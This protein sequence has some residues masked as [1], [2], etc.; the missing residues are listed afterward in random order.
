L[1]LQRMAL[2]AAQF[3]T[4]DEDILK[5]VVFSMMEILRGA[6]QD[7]SSFLVAL[8]TMEL[9][10]KVTGCADPYRAYRDRSTH[11]A[12]E[13]F[14]IM[15]DIVE[16]SSN[17]LWDACWAAIA[18]NLMDAVTGTDSK[19]DGLCSLPDMPFAVNDFNKFRST[20]I[21]AE[22]IVYL[23]DNAGEVFFDRILA[24]KGTVSID[25]FIKGF[26]FLNDALCEDV[27]PTLIGE[28]ATIRAIPLIKPIVMGQE[29][30]LN[31][32][33]KFFDL[34]RKADLV[35]IKGQANYELF[36]SL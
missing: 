34:A 9:I 24:E 20:L 33:A 22:K 25:Y 14:P 7:A 4:G 30:V 1:C 18:G 5:K 31:M 21:R 36:G 12:Q 8:Q 28:V 26:P 15:S 13:I 19:L 27:A 10:E 3:V 11:T 2:E 32:Y 23:A 17:P 6:P 35:V 16:R 29:H